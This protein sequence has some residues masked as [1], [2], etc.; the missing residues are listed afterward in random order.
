MVSGLIADR[1]MVHD[2]R[3]FAPKVVGKR[4]APRLESLDGR[5]V[6]LVDCLFDNSEAFMLQLQD[7]FAAHLPAVQTR[8]IKP[9]QSW[10]DD[11]AMRK[12][13]AAEGDAAILGVGL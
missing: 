12:Q 9:R 4:L 5:V 11:E 10:V 3:G 13:I 6:Y 1:L 8:I 7:W 2:P